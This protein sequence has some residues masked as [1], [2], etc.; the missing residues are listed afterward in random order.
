MEIL[1]N[2]MPH[3]RITRRIPHLPVHRP[4]GAVEVLIDCGADRAEGCAWDNMRYAYLGALL[5]YAE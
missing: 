1:P 4:C 5:S 2:P 3:Q